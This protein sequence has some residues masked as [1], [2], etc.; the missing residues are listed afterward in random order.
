MMGVNYIL[1][2]LIKVSHCLVCEHSDIMGRAVIL[3]LFAV[4]A[5][6]DNAGEK[7]ITDI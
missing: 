3:I 1:D 7:H 4:V 6:L 2:L 5:L